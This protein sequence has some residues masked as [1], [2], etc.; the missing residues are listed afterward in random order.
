MKKNGYFLIEALLS[1][2]FFSILLLSVFSMISFLQRRTV[3]SNFESDAGLVLQDGMEIT[4][5]VLLS[6]WLGYADGVYHPVY[7]A[8][9]DTWILMG[10]PE[11][12]LETRF[13]RGIEIKRVCRDASTGERI[14]SA[15]V[16]LADLDRNS[17]EVTVSVSWLEEGAMKNIDAKLLI[18]NVVT[19]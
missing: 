14:E 19:P 12:N 15:G 10:G 5:S 6:D 16:C 1:L 7:D 18:L 13:S 8:D 11:D 9:G 3:R 2:V 4:H 17:R